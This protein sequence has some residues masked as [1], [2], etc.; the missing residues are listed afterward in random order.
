MAKTVLSVDDSPSVRQM[1]K[2]TLAGAG[3][4]VLQAG[5]GA[6]GLAKAKD[7]A[8]DLVVTDLNMPVMDGLD[9]IRAL[10]QLPD[11]RGVPILFLTTESDTGLKQAAKA[12]GATGWITKPFQQEQLVAVVRKVLGA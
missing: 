10:R 4:N 1:V 11:Y 3:Y 2:L 5:D 8:V 7:T 6:E 12:A 9:L